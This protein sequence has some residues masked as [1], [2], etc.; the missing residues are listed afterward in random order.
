MAIHD[1]ITD[2]ARA[3][4]DIPAEAG[5]ELIPF[6]GRGSDRTYYRIKWDRKK[7][8][9]L[10]HYNPDR[11]ENPYF[12]DIGLFL[13]GIDVSTPKIIRH[14]PAACLIAIEDLGDT[15]LWALRAEPWKTRKPLYEKSLAIVHRLHSFPEQRF[16][17]DRVK[18]M[19]SF[20]PNLY[21]WERDYFRDNFVGILCGI[22]SDPAFDNK[23]EAEL[24]GLADSLSAD[25]PNLVHRD[26][27]SQNIMISEGKPYLIDFQGM[28]FGTRFY[29]LGSLLFDPYVSFSE[30]EREELL[31]FYFRL[32]GNDLEWENFLNA[33]YEASV[34]RLMQ[35]LGCYGFLGLT[36]GLKNY[37]AHVPNGIRNLRVALEKCASLPCLQELS[38]R[39]ENALV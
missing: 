9:I 3:A 10:S 20:G 14:D 31:S 17:S 6:G 11:I 32:P 23:L 21:R 22:K 19:E 29:D 37:L 25:R 5:V 39:C 38:M 16:P 35:A 27:Q 28:R 26:L 36:K 24:A 7:S 15:D 18:L 12:V 4:L 30:T 8:A 33:F 1:K 2:F 34:Q 13:S